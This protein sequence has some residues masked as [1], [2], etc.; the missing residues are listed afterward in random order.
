MSKLGG[1]LRSGFGMGQS[2]VAQ[3]LQASIAVQVAPVTL[4]TGSYTGQ[5]LT[6]TFVTKDGKVKNKRATNQLVLD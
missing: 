3:K 4:D 6:T 2:P 1:A 5:E